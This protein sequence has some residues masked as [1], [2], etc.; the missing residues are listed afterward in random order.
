MV[1]E[2]AGRHSPYFSYYKNLYPSSKPIPNY[3][4]GLNY[5]S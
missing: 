2:E 4:T 1:K 5:K 3:A